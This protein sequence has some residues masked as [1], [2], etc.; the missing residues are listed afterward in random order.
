MSN[1]RVKLLKKV[2]NNKISCLATYSPGIAKILDGNVDL[3]LIGDS[4][5][6][7]LYGMINTQGVT[8]NMM[9]QHGAC[10]VRNIKKS[11]TVI[12]MPYK[13]YENK[14]Q[15]LRNANEL[16]KY[17][18]ANLIKI[19]VDI[20]KVSIVKYL[21]EKNNNVIA[22]IGVTP[23]SYKDFNKIK[24]LG[25][26]VKERD[27]LITL[28]IEAEKAGAKCLLLECITE[29]LAKK[30]TESVNIPTIGIG[31]SKYCDGQILVF[32]DLVNLNLNKKKPKFV[33]SYFNLSKACR[34]AVKRYTKDVRE[35][36][37][38]TKKNAYQ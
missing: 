14:Y 18:K 23:Q 33:K 15:A 25:R 3:I 7:T 17:T 8:L 28:A 24:I 5:G 16:I 1:K 32:D 10:V 11:T 20:S 13:T 38:P 37:F 19:E 26:D 12:D 36:S 27:D 30:I 21:T 31:A 4:I 29:Y 2:F 34:S 9:K 22:H 6:T 35:G